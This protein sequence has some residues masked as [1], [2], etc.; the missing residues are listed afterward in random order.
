MQLQEAGF[1]VTET[2]MGDQSNRFAK[3]ENLYVKFTIHPKQDLK[4]SA[5]AGRPIFLDTEYVQIMVPGDKSSMV[6]R[7]ASQRDK[8]RFPRHY[9]A[10]KNNEGEIL[11]GT[12]LEQWPGLTRSQVE[13]MKYFNI[14]TVEQLA[15]LNDSQSQKFMG[16]AQFKKR[17]ADFL[18][19]AEGNA[20]TER[21]N[22]ELEARDNE[23]TS[24]KQGLA[25]LNNKIE[26]MAQAQVPEPAEEVTEED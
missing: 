22:S 9:A 13:E 1:D 3:D 12:P 18:E 7:P 26:A 25:E 20:A 17:A 10:F 6:N 15:N 5:K 4:K 24:L 16:I 23:I 19:A 11:E 2:A 8:D 21:L 14:R